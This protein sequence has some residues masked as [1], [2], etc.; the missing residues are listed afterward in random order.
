MRIKLTDVEA[1][2]DLLKRIAHNTMA[3]E[4]DL[5]KSRS[6]SDVVNSVFKDLW[7]RRDEQ[8]EVGL[9]IV[10]LA[11]RRKLCDY[12]R[13]RGAKK[14]PV[15]DESLTSEDALETAGSPE[16][17][18]LPAEAEEAIEWLDAT[19][20]DWAEAL[21]LHFFEGLTWL[22]VGQR[23]GVSERTAK[24]CGAE[25]LENLRRKLRHRGGP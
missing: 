14:R 17:G 16:G 18:E 15:F 11:I 22:E 6:V 24:R 9:A 19:H 8:P 5:G 1:Y 10:A 3:A 12:A 20:S 4:G 13:R 23:L 25:G 7:A 21:R 2:L